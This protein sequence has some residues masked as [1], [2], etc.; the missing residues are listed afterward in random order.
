V[1][2]SS[3]SHNSQSI[4]KTIR[5]ESGLQ[6]AILP[7]KVTNP[8]LIMSCKK[9]QS[10]YNYETIRKRSTAPYLLK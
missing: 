7:V 2:V 10:L 5:E 9:M 4:P 1:L 3:Q 6:L 8:G